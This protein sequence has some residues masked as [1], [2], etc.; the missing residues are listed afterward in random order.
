MP[1]QPTFSLRID[2]KVPVS[3][4]DLSKCFAGLAD[5]HRRFV[6]ARKGISAGHGVQ[7]Y[8][9]EVKSG[10]ILASLQALTPYALPFMEHA[11]TILDFA[12]YLKNAFHLMLGKELTKPDELKLQKPNYENLTAVLEPVAK[13]K[14]GV[15]SINSTFENHA[16][17]TIQINYLEANAIQNAGR[18]AIEHLRAPSTGFHEKVLLYWYQARNDKK[19]QKGDRAIIESISPTPAK[20]IFVSEGVKGKMLLGANNPFKRAF[21]VDVAVETIDGKPALYK[22][23]DVHDSMPRELSTEGANTPKL[24]KKPKRKS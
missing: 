10:S 2:H 16:P 7:L 15:I 3:V 24:L 1:D 19:S 12:C 5:E 14:D 8:V 22:I 17:V 20:T 4:L 21:I 11:V 6:E 9:K 13:D 23:L 18:R